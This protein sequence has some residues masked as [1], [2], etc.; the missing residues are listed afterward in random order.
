MRNTMLYM[1]YTHCI[2]HVI[3]NEGITKHIPILKLIS[4]WVQH[5]SGDYDCTSYSLHSTKVD[6]LEFEKTLALVCNYIWSG[7]EDHATQAKLVWPIFTSP[8]SRGGLGLIDLLSHNQK[9]Y[10]PNLWCEDSNQR[11][12]AGKWCCGYDS[13]TLSQK[14]G[15]IGTPKLDGF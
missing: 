4:N 7:K 11:M 12:I 14:E 5:T 9:P 10:S 6:T 3:L 15:P 2:S 8:K 13:L 1:W